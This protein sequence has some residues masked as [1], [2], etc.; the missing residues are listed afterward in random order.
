M[1]AGLANRT[2]MPRPL[3]AFVVTILLGATPL[4]AQEAGKSLSDAQ[5]RLRG[6]EDTLSASAQ[7][8]R[9]IEIEVET[10]RADR[11]RLNAALLDTGTKVREGETR[12][13][14]AEARLDNLGFTQ[15]AIR[16]SLESRRAVVAEVLAA[17]QRMG[18]KPPPAVLAR[19]EDM[20][21]AIR[22]SIL[23]GAVLPEL[24]AETEALSVDLREM[25]R[26]RDAIAA[27]RDELAPALAALAG[28]RGRLSALVQARQQNLAE[29]E[30]ALGAERARA[31]AL[32]AEAGSLKDLIARMEREVAAAG[33]AAEQA[34]KSDEA[35]RKQAELEAAGISAKAL[36]TLKDPARL[37]PAIAFAEAKGVLQWPAVGEMRKNWGMPDGYGGQEK[38]LS[39]ATRP[40]ASVSAPCDGWIAFSGPY[41]SYGQ[42]LI[43]NAG[44][45]YY[46]VLAGMERID[47]TV[48]QFVLAGEPIAAMGD[49]S[50][51]TAATLAIGAAEPILYIEFRKDGAAID[52]GPWW[53]K[54]ATEK[55]RG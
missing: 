22:A 54:P 46:V 2:L 9:K 29:A 12:I 8:R 42:L 13:A 4:C 38:G 33:Q 49:G 14:A 15:D 18:R 41:R 45:G 24:R 27:E 28:E 51:K 21:S 19:P 37:A 25:I 43:L 11:A 30:A 26:V 35:R 7:Q 47:A 52:P 3:P 16:R 20:L 17:L 44:G 39:L 6:V 40:N 1:M 34:R 32:A 53:A 48:G 31:A 55:V 23:L 5:M 10:V 36:S 50:V